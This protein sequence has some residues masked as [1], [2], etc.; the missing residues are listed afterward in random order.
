MNGKRSKV[1]ECCE[2]RSS[3]SGEI[4]HNYFCRFLPVRTGNYRQVRISFQIVLYT[5]AMNEK[6]SVHH[7]EKP[8]PLT[9]RF[10]GVASARP[11]SLTPRFSEVGPGACA[12]PNGFNRFRSF[13]VSS[14]LS[15][16]ILSALV[17]SC[18]DN[19]PQDPT[20]AFSPKIV[21]HTF[22]SS[23][24]WPDTAGQNKTRRGV[25]DS[26]DRIGIVRAKSQIINH[27]S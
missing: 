18:R 1:A 8:I 24:Q 2:P 25:A 7:R 11:V 15:T 12:P 3:T 17:G 16:G 13:P 21:L 23:G 5:N 10:S 4:V 20:Y 6:Y 22:P 9:L 19:T 26:P 27:Q 14:K